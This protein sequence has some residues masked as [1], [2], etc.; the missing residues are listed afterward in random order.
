MAGAKAVTPKQQR[1]AEEYCIDFNAT[2]A[3]IRAGYAKGQSAE[4]QGHRLLS[5]VKIKAEIAAIQAKLSE[6]TAI[7]L[8]SLTDMLR[9]TY[10]DAKE[11][12]ARPAQVAAVMG[13]AKLHGLGVEKHEVKASPLEAVWG[14]I[15]G[16]SQVS[17]DDDHERTTH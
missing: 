5:D 8:E 15:Q 14:A 13:L 10:D 7:T 9:E 3:A 2:Q 16:T 4:V 12:G 17:P 11:D 6:K 1:F